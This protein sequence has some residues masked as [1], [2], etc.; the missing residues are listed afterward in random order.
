MKI[1]DISL[2]KE[3]MELL[4]DAD[5]NNEALKL[6]SDLPEAT[7]QIGRVK[8]Y[9]LKAY[10]RLGNIEKADEIFNENGG[11]VL[12]DIREGERLMTELYLDLLQLKAER[13]GQPFDRATAKVP[14]K[15]DYRQT[16]RNNARPPR[17]RAK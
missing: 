4:T 9:I 12:P 1:D 6:A 11:L 10:I 5:M 2:A 14:V 8:I 3:A 7:Q 16:D 17:K 15:Y 13:D